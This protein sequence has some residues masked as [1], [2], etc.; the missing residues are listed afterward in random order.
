MGMITLSPKGLAWFL[1]SAKTMT[2]GLQRIKVLGCNKK[3]SELFSIFQQ[4][5]K[6]LFRNCHTSSFWQYSVLHKIMDL[7]IQLWFRKPYN[8]LL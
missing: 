4:F 2:K 6:Y 1:R 5:A 8:G 3:H 7:Q